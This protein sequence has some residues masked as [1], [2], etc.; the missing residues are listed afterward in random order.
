MSDADFDVTFGVMEDVRNG[1][2]QVYGQLG[3]I[4]E[5][6]D[7]QVKA[8]TIQFVGDTKEAF[9]LAHQRYDQAY[10][11]LS[12]S[13]NEANTAL[14]DVEESYQLGEKKASSLYGGY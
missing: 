12:Q 13:L 10:Q 4:G 9:A 3:Q 7:N 11:Q 14:T 5:N 8:G 6:L 2:N 1:L